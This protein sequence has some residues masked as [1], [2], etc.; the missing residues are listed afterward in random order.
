MLTGPGYTS[1]KAQLLSVPPYAAA[2]L[3]TVAIGFIADRTRQR[4]IANM[5]ISIIGMVGFAL[6][7]GA[8]SPGARYAGTYLGAMGIYPTISNTISWC[9]NNTEGEGCL[10][11]SL[12]CFC[13]A[14]GEFKQAYTSGV[15]R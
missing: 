6:M 11:V 3:L 14:N 8:K 13:H 4:G 2:A 5:L 9:S 15:S 1:I 7:M 12:L 10:F